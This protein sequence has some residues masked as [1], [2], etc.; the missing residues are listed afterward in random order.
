MRL[1]SAASVD[2]FKKLGLTL[3]LTTAASG[4]MIVV[5]VGSVSSLKDS[6]RWET[7]TNEVLATSEGVISSLKDAE[8]GER[9][10]VITQN[11]S[12]LEPYQQ[13]S[14]VIDSQLSKL[15]ELVDDNPTQ[16]TRVNKLVSLS[17][18]H[19]EVV[20]NV[21][22]FIEQGDV[23][24]ARRLVISGATKTSLDQIRV[25]VG[26]IQAEEQ[27]LLKIRQGNTDTFVRFS[28]A[29]I[30][31]ISFIIL[32]TLV[33]AYQMTVREVGLRKLAE[34]AAMET[35]KRNEQLAS[36]L[37]FSMSEASTE[38]SDLIE[39]GVKRDRLLKILDSRSAEG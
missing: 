13:S 25:L 9:G 11:E 34:R 14:E 20:G 15:R 7:H 5:L 17:S 33:Y 31:G 30:A 18:D 2:F 37:K 16:I 8:L 29:S 36:R 4:A 19:L 39:S 32:L 21:I 6:A 27:G 26:E 28:Y 1:I 10:Y 22:E 3:S 38:I 35:A 24:E 12:F 23:V